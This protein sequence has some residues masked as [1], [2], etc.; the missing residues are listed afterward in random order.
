MYP[1]KLFFIIEGEIKTFHNKQKLKESVTDKL[2]LQKI[3]RR[4]LHPEQEGKGNQEDVR[5]NKSH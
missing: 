4:I 5:K 1:V 2:T 3:L